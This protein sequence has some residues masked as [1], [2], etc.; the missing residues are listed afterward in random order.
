MAED[1]ETILTAEQLPDDPLK[2]PPPYWR[3]VGAI[4]HL[5]EALVGLHTL[6]QELIPVHADTESRLD[7]Y[8]Q[9]YPENRHQSDEAREEFAEIIDNLGVIEHKIRLKAELACLM[10][11]IQAEDHLN[12]F[13]VFNLHKDIAES[14]EKLSPPE[15]LLVACAAVGSPGVKK[16]VA[17]EAIQKLVSWR[18]AFTHGHCVDRPTKSL[19]HNHLISPDE[20]PGVPSSVREVMVLV[21]AFLLVSDHLKAVSLNPYTSS[22]SVNVEDIRASL[23]ML[24]RYQF[25]GDNIVY[26]IALAGGVTSNLPLQKPRDG[27]PHR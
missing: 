12:R 24:R 22:G 17:F 3:S 25:D 16:M 26:T 15:K 19:R 6:L 11:A 9:K 27:V 4:F 23:E 8:Y 2:M 13:C 1:G 10:S 18:N 21:R 14:V 5:E 7:A 20:Y